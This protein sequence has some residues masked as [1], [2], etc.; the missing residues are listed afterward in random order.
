VVRTGQRALGW[1]FGFRK[2]HL[3]AFCKKWARELAPTQSAP[4]APP[5]GHRPVGRPLGRGRAAQTAYPTTQIAY[6][7][8]QPTYP[9]PLAPGCSY[10]A[11][12]PSLPYTPTSL[13]YTPTSPPIHPTRRPQV[14]HPTTSQLAYPIPRPAYPT[15]SP[16][17]TSYTNNYPCPTL[18]TIPLPGINQPTYLYTY[19]PSTIPI[20][21]YTYLHCSQDAFTTLSRQPPTNKS[22]QQPIYIHIE[23]PTN[24]CYQYIYIYT[25]THIYNQETSRFS[26]THRPIYYTYKD[27]IQSRQIQ[28]I[29]RYTT[30]SSLNARPLSPLLYHYPKDT[31]LPTTNP[32]T[33]QPGQ[34]GKTTRKSNQIKPLLQ[35]Y[36][37]LKSALI[38][39]PLPPRLPYT[40]YGCPQLA[41][42]R[43]TDSPAA[44]EPDARAS[45]LL[46]GKPARSSSL[47][48]PPTLYLP[49]QPTLHHLPPNPG[50]LPHTTHLP[51][52][53]SPTAYPIPHTSFPGRLPYTC[54]PRQPTLHPDHHPPQ[55]AYPIPPSQ[56]TLHQPPT[57]ARSPPRRPT[58]YPPFVACRR[59]ASR[60]LGRSFVAQ[61]TYP[62]YPRLPTSLPYPTRIPTSKDTPSR[63]TLYRTRGSRTRRRDRPRPRP[64]RPTLHHSTPSH[65]RTWPRTSVPARLPYTSRPVATC[66]APTTNTTTFS[67]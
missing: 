17:T 36:P 65:Q 13:P 42:A 21:L 26:K 7:I 63:P 66:A 3:Y 29:R 4:G 18:T 58:L 44:A 2:T 45:G 40:P 46:G 33:Y 25:H 24:N 30:R 55:V 27:P 56:P 19:K 41:R 48:I 54:P 59:P 51:S 31:Y 20:Y 22:I 5:S 28:L 64:K 61:A 16:H 15:P 32:P 23:I 67:P 34:L 37:R 52:H 14:A 6:P 8:P 43:V 50:C 49:S 53:T 9:I 38:Y 47:P 57:G 12:P 35:A 10:L 11:P 60:S 62:T 39:T 1:I